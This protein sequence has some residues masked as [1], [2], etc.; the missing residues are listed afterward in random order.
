MVG[1]VVNKTEIKFCV[2]CRHHRLI[3]M[4]VHTPTGH[5]YVETPVCFRAT[6]LVTG[7]PIHASAEHMRRDDDLCGR[8]AKYFELDQTMFPFGRALRKK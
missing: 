5:K 7:E 4:K 3:E 6:N 8:K 2:N 1:A